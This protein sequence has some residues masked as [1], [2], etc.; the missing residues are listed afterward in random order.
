MEIRDEKERQ[1]QRKKEERLH[2]YQTKCDEMLSVNLCVCG[3]ERQGE[4]EGERESKRERERNILVKVISFPKKF[5]TKTSR[6]DFPS[7]NQGGKNLNFRSRS[8]NRER[9]NHDVYL[10]HL[11][12]LKN[13]VLRVQRQYCKLNVRLNVES[14]CV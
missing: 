6:T 4:R 13:I 14:T 2:F 10:K 5:E 8:R 7:R 11:D 1:R 3:G 12:C 9:E